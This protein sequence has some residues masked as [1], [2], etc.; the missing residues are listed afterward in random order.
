M[1][2]QN[3]QIWGMENLQAVEGV[4]MRSEKVIVLGGM[5]NTKI[6]GLYFFRR[7]S[8]D[9][10]AYKSMLRYYGLQQVQKLPGSP[11]IQQDGAPV[12]TANTV[13]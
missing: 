8:V 11:I 7:S 3:A 12:H 6:I 9:S 5:H 1:N 2:Q 4:P 10:A 13:K